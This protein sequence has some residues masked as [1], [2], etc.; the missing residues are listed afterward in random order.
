MAAGVFGAVP[1]AGG[2]IGIAAFGLVVVAYANSE[3]KTMVD[4][5]PRYRERP[6]WPT[7]KKTE[8]V[9]ERLWNDREP[10]LEE[11]SLFLDSPD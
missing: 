2:A 1:L 3:E 5:R 10:S 11:P 7:T 6:D 4:V 9:A 8:D